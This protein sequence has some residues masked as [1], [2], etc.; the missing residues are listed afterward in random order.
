MKKNILLILLGL[1]FFSCSSL[2]KY[3]SYGFNKNGINIRTKSKYDEHGF[4][5]DKKNVNTQELYDKYGFDI[6]GINKNHR[7]SREIVERY[8]FIFS[9]SWTNTTY[10]N[11]NL[12]I[13]DIYKENQNS[14]YKTEDE[15][16]KKGKKIYTKL[17]EIIKSKTEFE[18]NS[19]V[20]E[21]N[22]RKL[23]S[24]RSEMSPL[25]WITMK[26]ITY[27]LNKESYEIYPQVKNKNYE[28][29]TKYLEKSNVYGAKIY[30]SQYYK[31]GEKVDFIIPENYKEKYGHQFIVLM[32]KEIAK[33]YP[34]KDLEIDFLI[35]L[36]SIYG[37]NYQRYAYKIGDSE[38]DE[39]YISFNYI[40]GGYKLKYKGQVIKEEI[41]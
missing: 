12:S 25:Y 11:D 2:D 40:I 27:N 16:L 29:K 22:E 41:F 13:K 10:I 5:K 28:S 34:T 20:F 26:N 35:K 38:W 32:S 31:R 1:S 9:N 37:V 23:E 36:K 33:Q 7:F 19:D 39:D 14:T 15:L 30:I 8:P 4:N 3:D 21:R 6:D 17:I 24:L 18:T